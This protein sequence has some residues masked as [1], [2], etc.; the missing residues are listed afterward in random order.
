MA[1][2]Q[3]SQVPATK[4]IRIPD[5]WGQIAYH[6]VPK[7]PAE[8][9]KL[10]DLGYRSLD[11][12]LA[13]RFHTTPA[14]LKELNPGGQPAS[15]HSGTPT[16]TP[17]AAAT[18]SPTPT[19][20]GAADQPIFHPGQL[21]RVPN[22]GLDAEPSA[23]GDDQTWAATL[24]SLGVGAQQPQVARVVVDKSEGWLKGYDGSGKLVA[25]FTVTTGSQHDPLPIGEWKIVAI[26]KNPK[27]HYNPDLFW[28]AKATDKAATLPP[29]PN[30]PVGV[31][32]IDLSKE[33]YGIHGTPEPQTIGRTESHG[34]VRLTNWDAA[35]LANMVT[36][37]TKVVFQA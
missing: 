32:W 16:A 14:V 10:S 18:P 22:V 17:S 27:F 9:A 34:C 35:R 28:D 24:A 33:H 25:M 12:K 20:S 3:W 36:T 2:S 6:P 13:E 7:E 4:V 21:V 31:V 29:G 19:A 5:S 37:A 15:L 8:Q 1:L 11:E 30:G 26:D 23:A